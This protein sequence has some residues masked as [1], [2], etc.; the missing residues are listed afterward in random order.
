MIQENPNIDWAARTV[1]VTRRGVIHNLPTIRQAIDGAIDELEAKVNCISVTAF[2]WAIRKKRIKEDTVFLGLI[3]KVQEPTEQVDVAKQ[4]KG[5][6]DLGAVHV[7][8]EDMPECIKAVLKEYN[9]IFP[10]DLPP[11]LPPIRMG[12]E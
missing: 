7:R 3:Q 11:G 12:R 2:K 5:K 10:Q 9:N 8:R 1:R 6:S 4:Y